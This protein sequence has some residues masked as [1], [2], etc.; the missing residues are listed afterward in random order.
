M[1]NPATKSEI[2]KVEQVAQRPNPK[3]ASTLKLAGT[4]G[5]HAPEH[6]SDCCAYDPANS[7]EEWHHEIHHVHPAAMPVGAVVARSTSADWFSRQAGLIPR[8]SVEQGR[9]TSS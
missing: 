2:T 4:G 7:V 1:R 9:A 3:G 5:S 8:R 6:A